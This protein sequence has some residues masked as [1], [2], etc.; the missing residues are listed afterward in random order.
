MNRPQARTK[1][2]IFRKKA[3]TDEGHTYFRLNDFFDFCKK[4]NWEMDKTKTGNLVQSLEDIFVT[5]KCRMKISG[6]TPQLM[7]IKAMKK[8]EIKTP[9]VKY[10]ETPF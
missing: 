6:T 7:Q 3:W 2:E 8:I 10:E 9:E 4:N 1:E 5:E